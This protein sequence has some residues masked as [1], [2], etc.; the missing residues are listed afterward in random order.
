MKRQL[1]EYYSLLETSHL[2]N[3]VLSS[4]PLPRTLDPNT[5]AAVPGRLF[6]VLIL[7]RDSISV[8]LRLPFFFFPLIMHMPAYIMGRYGGKLAA[9]E[10]TRAQSKVV[11]GLLSLL[12]TYSAAFTFLWSMFMYTPTGALIAAGTVYLF[13]LYHIRVIDGKSF[14]LLH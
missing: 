4:L 6:A 10:E 5:P 7:L 1:L 11:F 3:S 13:A 12:L 8:L 9:D 14:L 2:T